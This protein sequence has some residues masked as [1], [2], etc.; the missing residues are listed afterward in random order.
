MS[1]NTRGSFEGESALSG[2]TKIATLAEM[3]ARNNAKRASHGSHLLW[4]QAYLSLV[5]A[6]ARD[7]GKR[8]PRSLPGM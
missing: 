4:C 8:I 7:L 2:T 1:M 3:A 6:S 5:R